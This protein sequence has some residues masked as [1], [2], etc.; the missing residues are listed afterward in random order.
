MAVP[1]MYSSAS[2]VHTA[3]AIRHTYVRAPGTLFRAFAT[4]RLRN[5]IMHNLADLQMAIKCTFDYISARC[6][7][8]AAVKP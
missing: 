5:A 8:A 7:V 4:T 3:Y 6:V 2:A 1:V